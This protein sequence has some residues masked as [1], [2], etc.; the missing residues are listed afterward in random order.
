[1]GEPN[2]SFDNSLSSYFNSDSPSKFNL[3]DITLSNLDAQ[4]LDNSVGQCNTP[5]IIR[6][7]TPKLDTKRFVKPSVGK[8][9]KLIP[10]KNGNTKKNTVGKRS[11]TTTT[12]TKIA[13]KASKNKKE[14]RASHKKDK[15]TTVSKGKAGSKLTQMMSGGGDHVIDNS[16]SAVYNSAD[17][18]IPT[19]VENLDPFGNK[20]DSAVSYSRKASSRLK[21]CKN[22]ECCIVFSDEVGYRLLFDRNLCVFFCETCGAV[23]TRRKSTFTVVLD[24]TMA[25]LKGGIVKE[26]GGYTGGPGNCSKKAATR[27]W[28]QIR[29]ILSSQTATK[30]LNLVEFVNCLNE[31]AENIYDRFLRMYKD[32]RK[33]ADTG[34]KRTSSCLTKILTFDQQEKIQLAGFHVSPVFKLCVRRKKSKLCMPK[35]KSMRAYSPNPA[36]KFR[37]HFYSDMN[38]KVLFN[39]KEFP[40][41]Q[42]EYICYMSRETSNV[43]FEYTQKANERSTTAPTDIDAVVRERPHVWISNV[44]SL[45]HC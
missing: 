7:S 18:T 13:G 1:M 16:E 37:E 14:T 20:L 12:K 32:K 28:R 10:E 29:K 3:S 8:G 30:Y 41:K 35:P 22:K 38:R 4:L 6:T 2:L 15:I 36:I 40:S 43:N 24:D 42:F 31:S 17:M 19:L 11:K 45:Q 33:L 34:S 27:V 9:I 26:L 44:I 39:T 21:Q 25:K 23:N 5:P